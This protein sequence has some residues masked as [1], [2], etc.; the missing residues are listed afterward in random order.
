MGRHAFL[1][2]GVVVGAVQLAGHVGMALLLV[3]P[4]W[5]KLATRESVGIAI[6]ATMT[7]MLPDSDL[8]ARHFIDIQHHGIFHTVFFVVPVC[9]VLALVVTWFYETY[10]WQYVDRENRPAPRTA[11][12]VSFGAFLV[13]GF[14]HLV[15]DALT[16][17]DVAPAIQ[18]FYPLSDWTMSVD[19][20]WVYNP[21]V[22]LGT[23]ALAIAV[24]VALW[25]IDPYGK[26]LTP[27]PS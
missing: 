21:V 18:P 24:H 22:N 12:W 10:G 6:L 16:S 8:V 19:I 20:F 7:A 4:V 17:P 11:L 2:P 26:T 14:A 9:F 3:S 5:F 13:G 25:R 1:Y 23:L 27:R 15:G